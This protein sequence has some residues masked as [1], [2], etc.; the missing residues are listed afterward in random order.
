ME[1]T[2]ILTHCG[3]LGDFLYCLPIAAWL[4][5]THRAKIHFV[6][7]ECFPPFHHI[8]RLLHTLPFTDR[9][10]LV[11]HQCR[12]F[13]AGGQPYKFNPADFGIEG[14]YYN[15]GIRHYPNKFMTAFCAEEHGFDWDRGFR[16]DV[17]AVI[18]TDKILRS[19]QGE[20]AALAPQS[21][22]YP[23][24]ID[25]LELAQMLLAAKERWVWYS[26]PAALM[27]LMRI[28]FNLV[29]EQGHPSRDLYLNKNY[30]G[31]ELI[32][33]VEFIRKK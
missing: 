24:P 5:N 25:L 26:G 14:E 19:E 4:Y 16:L 30:F 2:I 11:G 20:V 12:D 27:Y 17:G 9:V 3:K 7:P 33:P 13:D 10:S 29:W 6:F 1:E 22:P 28:P 8:K 18:R 15:L 21:E 32:T 31:G 23:I